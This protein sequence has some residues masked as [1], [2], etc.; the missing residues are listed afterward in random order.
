M[1][2]RDGT[3]IWP[4]SLEFIGL[5]SPPEPGLSLKANFAITRSKAARHIDAD[6]GCGFARMG[7]A[8]VE[9]VD[10]EVAALAQWQIIH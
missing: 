1:I 7:G 6:A 9:E 5:Q 2:G 10:D 3:I 8:S 4:L